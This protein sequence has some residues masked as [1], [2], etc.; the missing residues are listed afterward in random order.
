MPE[1]GDFSEFQL[2]VELDELRKANRTLQR[3]LRKAKERNEELVEAAFD[4]A[5][6]ALLTLG[7]V[8]PVPKPQVRRRPGKPE[9]AL[10]HLT[11]WQAAK[12]T[13]TYN[14]DVMLERVLRYCDKAER[15]TEIQRADH[16]VRECTVML[17]GDML[18]GIFN[19]PSQPFEIDASL[20]E[21]YELVAHAQAQVVRRALAIYD[22]VHVVCEW[23]N[24]GRIGSKRAAVPRSDNMDRMVQRLAQE[25][26]RGEKRLTWQA[27]AEDMQRVTIGNY[28]ALLFH[29]DE[30]GRNGYASPMTIVQHVVR[31]QSGSLPGGPWPFTDAYYGH[32]HT[33]N[34]WA[35]PNG[36]GAVYQTG[37]P[38]SDNRYAG[39][40]MGASARPSQ[41][42]H[43]IDPEK[44][45]VT[46][47]YRVAL[48]DVQ[49]ST[50]PKLRAV[51]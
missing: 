7:K 39:V 51:A 48:D 44:G 31:W 11:D 30:V 40:H 15:L 46:D 42:L 34:E 45:R 32:Y 25:M 10:W 4:G 16:P 5:K 24:H 6:A 17:G 23:G 29:G 33:H 50:G 3:Q 26:L 8:P 21:Q 27:S 28:H 12:V 37:S 20:F 47:Q 36:M 1:D 35:L 49:A 13:S 9:V 38:E 2:H 43:F 18:E 19:F 41:R 22:S 14:K